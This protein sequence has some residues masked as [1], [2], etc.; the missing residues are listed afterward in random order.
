MS[1]LNFFGNN[2]EFGG[3]IYVDDESNSG[4]C[5][6]NPYTRDA[7]K[8]E[9]FIRVVATHTILTANSNY[10]LNNIDFD[11]NSA[12]GNSSVLFG[13]LLDRCTVSL[14]N[15]VDRTLDLNDNHFQRY[16]GDGLQY[17]FDISTGVSTDSISSLPVQ[18][19]LC[20]NGQYNC[21][22]VSGM[23]TIETRKGESFSISVIAVDEVYR[24]VNAIIQ[25]NLH[26][27]D[28][29]LIE[30]QVTQILAIDKCTK[31]SFKVVSPRNDEVLTLY[32]SDGLCKDAVL[33]RLDLNISFKPCTCLVGFEPTNSHSTNCRCRCH[34]QI[35]RFVQNCDAGKHSFQRRI[36]VWIS[37]FNSTS[38]NSSGYL[39]YQ[40]CP[41][42]Y[43]LLPNKSAQVNLNLV[44]GEDAQCA[45]NRTGTLCGACKPGLS[46]SLGSSRCLK[47]PPYWPAL[48]VG[49]TVF[50]ALAGFGLVALFMLLNL[51]VAVGT[52][53]GLLLYANVVMASRIA[54]L[55]YPE[56]GC[57]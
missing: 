18:V 31:I 3:A 14:F 40:Y 48:F 20:S 8:S 26:S 37:Y 30:G 46:L 11:L 36:N 27:S 2:A 33:S 47:C 38:I 25:A 43:C 39:I 15:E 21:T 7:P 49:I 23:S 51:T 28:S 5:V 55:P 12:E 10:T 22:H 53:N 57:R 44:H 9:C 4:A 13:G 34:S 54:L 29:D 42:D 56:Q 1:A 6:S 32:S 50:A 16:S 41:F 45:L 24:P 52:I 35:E 17:L 19:C